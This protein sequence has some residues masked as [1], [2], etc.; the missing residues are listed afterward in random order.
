[1]KKAQ[2][3]IFGPDH[4][5]NIKNVQKFQRT[6]RNRDTAEAR[7]TTDA[8]WEYKKWEDDERDY[9]EEDHCEESKLA[10]DLDDFTF[11]DSSRTCGRFC[12][13]RRTSSVWTHEGRCEKCRTPRGLHPTVPLAPPFREPH[14]VR[15]GQASQHSQHESL[16]WVEI[17][18]RPRRTDPQTQKGRTPKAKIRGTDPV[19]VEPCTN[20][21]YWPRRPSY[22]QVESVG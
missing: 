11:D 14:E 10:G 13:R 4:T 8:D 16:Q 17:R 15:R 9:P 2:L 6:T 5:P 7:C 21:K 1:M 18:N 3:K 20:S 12:Q 22:K 19:A